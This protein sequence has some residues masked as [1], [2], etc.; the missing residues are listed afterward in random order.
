LL[1]SENLLGYQ[2]MVARQN[3]GRMMLLLILYIS[4][5]K[6]KHLSDNE[7]SLG[8]DASKQ[9]RIDDA[10]AEVTFID[11]T[12]NDARNMNNKISNSKRILVGW[13]HELVNVNVI[14]SCK[15]VVLCKIDAIRGNLS[16]FLTIV[17]AANGGYDRI[18]LWKELVMHKKGKSVHVSM[19]QDIDNLFKVKLNKEEAMSMVEDVSDAE[20]KKAMFQ[21]DDNKAPGPDGFSSH[22]Y[23]KAWNAIGE[24]VCKAIDLQKAYDTINWSFLEKILKGFGIH[25]R[26]VH[27]VMTCVTTTT[28]SIYVNGEGCGFFKGSR[29]LRQGD[30]MYSY[31][32]TLVI[33]ILNLLMI[34]RIENNN[35]KFKYHYGC[36]KLKITHICFA[37]DLLMFSHGD[38]ASVEM[39]KETIKEFGSVCVLLPNYN[40]ITILFG[41]VKEDDRQSILSIISFRVEKMPIKYLG[42]PLI[43][44]RIGDCKSLVEKVRNKVLSYKIKS[45]SYAGRLQL[46]INSLLKEFLWNQD[47]KANGRAKVAW[48]N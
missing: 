29:G 18:E 11:E 30:P 9:G 10:D 31:L 36:E 27:W 2:D 34:R 25:D 26:M 8:E 19:I 45:L 37:D 12:S 7:E 24:D 46:E 6:K 23:K 42:V 15:Q 41:S 1:Q 16:M 39:I 43:S 20:I 35:G 44:K 38:R 14:H 48:K 17:Y 32:F 33:E 28:F 5:P 21:I 22:F 4:T 3:I 40:K 13:N 47:E